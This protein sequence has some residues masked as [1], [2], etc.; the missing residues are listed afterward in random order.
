VCRVVFRLTG[1]RAGGPHFGGHF[2]MT[3]ATHSLS[4]YPVQSPTSVLGHSILFLY[5]Y[6]TSASVGD[7]VL[8]YW[9]IKRPLVD[10]GLLL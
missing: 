8:D 6:F 3:T 1:Q 4:D 7:P 9:W 10:S 2:S 5:A